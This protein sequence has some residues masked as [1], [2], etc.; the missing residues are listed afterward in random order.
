M[1]ELKKLLPIGSVVKLSTETKKLMIIGIFQIG[2][3]GQQYD[4]SGVV[5]PEGIVDEN[6]FLFNHDDIETVCFKGFENSERLQMLA[7][8][9]KQLEQNDLEATEKIMKIFVDLYNSKDSKNCIKVNVPKIAKTHDID[10]SAMLE[11]LEILVNE[12]YLLE[13]NAS[14]HKYQITEAGLEI[15]ESL[16]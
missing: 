14:K 5:Y 1:V 4:Y 8:I 9:E 15:I 2:A 13:L 11:V 12:E 10:Q 16:E 6:Q 3:D 7:E